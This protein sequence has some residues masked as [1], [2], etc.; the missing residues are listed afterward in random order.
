M[1]E[2]TQVPTQLY[3]VFGNL[4][5]ESFRLNS[6]FSDARLIFSSK[7]CASE[8]LTQFNENFFFAFFFCLA[9]WLVV[10]EVYREAL[11]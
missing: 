6:F 10:Y 7:K 3:W 5:M 9:K 4:F 11:E 2:G 1:R 8:L